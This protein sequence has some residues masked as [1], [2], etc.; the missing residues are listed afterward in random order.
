MALKWWQLKKK[1]R[2]KTAKTRLKK[3]LSLTVTKEQSEKYGKVR[4]GAKGAVITKGGAYVKYAKKS[5]AA[6]SF[7]SA[8]KKGCAGDS[9]GFS[10]DGRKYSCAK[11]SDNPA[12][13]KAASKSPAVGKSAAS[14]IVSLGK[15]PTLKKKKKSAPKNYV[16]RY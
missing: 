9:K 11:A 3:D 15:R 1:S 12:A 10:W 6:G 13:K 4:K 7:R 2:A 16:S 14:K 8:F 5:K